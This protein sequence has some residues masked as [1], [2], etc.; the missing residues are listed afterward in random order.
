M[1]RVDVALHKAV[2]APE[3]LLVVKHK[4]YTPIRRPFL[5]VTASDDTY[6]HAR[7]Q[8]LVARTASVRVRGRSPLPLPL[9]RPAVPVSSPILLVSERPVK[10]TGMLAIRSGSAKKEWRA[11]TALFSSVVFLFLFDIYCSIIN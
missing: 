10:R 3:L 1:S 8:Q 11:D 6:V 5:I 9:P 7:R 2:G 4:H